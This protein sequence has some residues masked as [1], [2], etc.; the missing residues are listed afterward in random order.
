M[1]AHELTSHSAEK[2]LSDECLGDG[3]GIGQSID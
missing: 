2:R 1:G 3:E